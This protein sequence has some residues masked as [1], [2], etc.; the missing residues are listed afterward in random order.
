MKRLE[1]FGNRRMVNRVQDRL[2][3][4]LGNLTVN[5]RVLKRS[6]ETADELMWRADVAGIKSPARKIEKPEVLP[7][8][9]LGLGR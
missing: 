1:F 2:L 6:V 4:F 7:T 8:R 3:H 9:L 5:G